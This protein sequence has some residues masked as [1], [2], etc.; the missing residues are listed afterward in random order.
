MRIALGAD[1]VAY[2]HKQALIEYLQNLGHE[3]LDMGGDLNVSNN[4]PDY[5]ELVGRAVVDGLAD[6]GIVICGT[7]IGMSIAANKVPGVRAAL[8][9][10]A[11]TVTRSRGHN[12]ANVLAL[13]SWVVSI[14]H[15][16]ELVELWLKTPY[17]AGRHVPRLEKIR[18]LE[19]KASQTGTKMV[20]HDEN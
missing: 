6:F 16:I 9:H 14:P 7:G 10:N 13:G 15:A 18:K 19:L 4:Y 20:S 5:A 11:F 12:D 8:C 3:L 2:D 1:W 17:D